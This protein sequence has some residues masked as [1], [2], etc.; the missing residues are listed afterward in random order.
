MYTVYVCFYTT[1]AELGNCDR[2]YL[3]YKVE[4]IYRTF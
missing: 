3:N 2:D 4:N 1:T